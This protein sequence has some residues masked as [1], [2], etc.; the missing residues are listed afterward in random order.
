MKLLDDLRVLFLLL[1][2]ERL[3]RVERRHD[4]GSKARRGCVAANNASAEVRDAGNLLQLEVLD[5]V[6]R[7]DGSAVSFFDLLLEVL[8]EEEDVNFG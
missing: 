7:S 1:L 4:V 5:D 2:S 6:V 8:E 3:D